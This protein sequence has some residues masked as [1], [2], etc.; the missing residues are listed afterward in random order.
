LCPEPLIRLATEADLDSV[1]EIQNSSP[2]AAHWN[3]HD[4]L[5][6]DFRVAVSN[7]AVCENQV[8][9]FAV[10]RCVA[11]DE[12]ELLNLA[13]HPAFRRRGV[14]RKLLAA[15]RSSHPGTLWLEVRESNAVALNFYK[16]LGF[17]EN[18]KRLG[19]YHD[20]YESG[21]VMKFHS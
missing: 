4:Y 8:A 2:E 14:G 11:D 16:T 21:I 15:I 7:N 18:R 12:S 1:A 3:V 13:V 19:Y 17:Q 9:G 5:A 6:Y 10:A 20:S